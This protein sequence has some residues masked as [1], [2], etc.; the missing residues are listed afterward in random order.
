MKLIG[1][2]CVVG[3][4][5]LWLLYATIKETELCESRGGRDTRAGCIKTSCLI[6]GGKE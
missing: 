5:L 1:M 6:E 4:P 2:V 3:I